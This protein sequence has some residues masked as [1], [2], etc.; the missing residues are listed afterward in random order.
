LHLPALDMPESPGEL[1]S[2]LVADLR[3]IATGDLPDDVTTIAKLCMLDWLGVTF[4]G[5]HEPLVQ[6]LLEEMPASASGA[7]TLIG[8][9]QRMAPLHAALI[10]GAAGDALDFSDCIRVMNGHAT[11]TV[12]PAAL[13]LAEANGKSGADLLRAFVT[14]VEAACRVGA[15][16][17]EGILLTPFHP[18][19]VLGPFGSAAAAAQLLQ[20]DDAQWSTALAIAGTTAAGLAASVGTM[21]KPLHAG[22]AAA[23]GVLAAGLA[24]RGFTG[25]TAVLEH[26]HGFLA[27][28]S[29]KIDA[30]ALAAARGRFFIR[31]TLVKQHAACQLTHGSIENMLRLRSDTAFAADDIK[32]IQLA[33]A[34]SSLRVCDI[35]APRT[36]LEAKFS[37][38]T[39]A[40]MALLGLP[41]DRLETYTDA[42]AQSPEIAR[43]RTRVTVEGRPDLPV[44]ISVAEIELNDGRVLRAQ[45][46]ERELDVALEHRRERVCAKFAN[47]A[48]ARIGRDRAADLR[49]L[50]LNLDRLNSIAAVLSAIVAGA[51]RAG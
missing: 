16:V 40:A 18:T 20:L 5:A 41:T 10:N 31:E 34:Q 32:Q 4:A 19:A 43:L 3:A 48:D 24:R 15:M 23:N 21:S 11:A 36:G 44:E 7:C 33:I 14:G 28:H 17:G 37:I 39:L 50:V 25:A 9:P 13:A 47:L 45:T 27:A 1:T 29:A 35:V 49:D 6:M 38:R 30:G 2:D 26:P 46:D 8:R 42:L 51:P 22:T 12:L